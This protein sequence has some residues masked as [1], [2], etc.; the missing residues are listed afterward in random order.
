M[1]GILSHPSCLQIT[2]VNE[3]NFNMLNPRI[4]SFFHRLFPL[5]E[6][7]TLSVPWIRSFQ[8]GKAENI[9][10][11]TKNYEGTNYHMSLV[12]QVRETCMYNSVHTSYWV[13]PALKTFFYSRPDEWMDTYSPLE[14]AVNEDHQER[15]WGGQRERRL[16]VLLEC[17]WWNFDCLKN[18]LTHLFSNHR[19]PS[20]F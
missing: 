8:D 18:T 4:F 19:L 17:Y 3:P 1:T 11:W 6:I 12:H 20:I 5:S 14:P 15:T 7:Q 2:F 16:K 13:S 10:I 9:F